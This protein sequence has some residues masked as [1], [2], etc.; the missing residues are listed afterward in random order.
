[1][2]CAFKLV[3]PL[4]LDRTAN[5]KSR[6]LSKS[7]W[8]TTNTPSPDR[9]ARSRCPTQSQNGPAPRALGHRMTIFCVT[10]ITQSIRFRQQSDRVNTRMSTDACHQKRFSPAAASLKWN[11]AHTLHLG[12]EREPPHAY[13]LEHRKRMLYSQIAH[14]RVS[15][16]ITRTS[17]S[18]PVAAAKVSSH[19]PIQASARAPVS[20]GTNLISLGCSPEIWP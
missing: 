8:R 15:L 19:S 7:I 3:S 17:I 11:A 10:A 18:H 13:G 6:D 12:F 9:E 16:I 5:G 20:N 14:L 4:E 1:M 2:I